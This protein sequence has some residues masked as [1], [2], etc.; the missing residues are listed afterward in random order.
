MDA[1]VVFFQQ[2]PTHAELRACLAPVGILQTREGEFYC[3]LISRDTARHHLYLDDGG[4]TLL[5]EFTPTELEVLTRLAAGRAGLV[6]YYRNFDFLTA[7]LRRLTER[8]PVVLYDDFG[9]FAR[10]EDFVEFTS[11]GLWPQRELLSGDD[12]DE[13]Q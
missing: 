9:H 13:D 8:W 12:A 11:S 7:T 6:L 3:T 1:A 5:A 10:G 4:D 2:L